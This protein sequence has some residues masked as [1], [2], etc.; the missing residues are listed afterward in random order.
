MGKP[1]SDDPVES[2]NSTKSTEDLKPKVKLV[3]TDSNIFNVLGVAVEALRKSNLKDKNEKIK[4]MSD[5]VF[6]SSSYT[7]ALSII[8]DYVDPE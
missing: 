8:T 5:K 6:N 4:E 7:E 2:S 1:L 3:G